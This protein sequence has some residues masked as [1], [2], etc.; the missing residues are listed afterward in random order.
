M[1]NFLFLPALS[2]SLLFTAV[3]PAFAAGPDFPAYLFFANKISALLP[4]SFCGRPVTLIVSDRQTAAQ[5]GYCCCCL[6]LSVPDFS[7]LFFIRMYFYSYVFLL[8]LSQPVRLYI[9]IALWL[10]DYFHVHWHRFHEPAP[11]ELSVILGLFLLPLGRP[12]LGF[13]VA[14]ML[15]GGVAFGLFLL[16]FGRPGLFFGGS[17]GLGIISSS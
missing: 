13:S 9:R 17:S 15:S 3:P 11:T 14:G 6:F 8:V 16:P 1:F 7:Y 10:N 4:S 2:V 5:K 12:R